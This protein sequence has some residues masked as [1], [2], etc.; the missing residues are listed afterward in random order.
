MIKD[1]RRVRRF[2]KTFSSKMEL[3][4]LVTFLNCLLY[5][6]LKNYQKCLFGNEYILD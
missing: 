5:I 2:K 4:K 1:F 3:L 6:F